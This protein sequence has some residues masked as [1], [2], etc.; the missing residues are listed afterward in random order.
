MMPG[1]AEHYDIL[2]VGHDH[3]EQLVKHLDLKSGGR[4]VLEIKDDWTMGR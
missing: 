1:A 2:V 4:Y 3:R